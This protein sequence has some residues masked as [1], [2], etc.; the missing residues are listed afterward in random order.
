MVLRAEA[1]SIS[2]Q[3]DVS[4]GWLV[5]RFIC[6]DAKL[7]RHAGF[8]GSAHLPSEEQHLHAAA[9]KRATENVLSETAMPQHG[10]PFS[11]KC[12][13]RTAYTK[14]LPKM[15]GK[16][17]LLTAD[18]ASDEQLTLQ[19]LFQGKLTGLL[20]TCKDV[21]HAMRRVA[22]RTSFADPFLQKVCLV[23]I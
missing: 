16:I 4:K 1:D 11:N 10:M 14:L 19:L 23:V 9:S 13:R 3:Q 22:S 5:I 17:E 20:L 21:A 7:V 6:A 18:G 2:L 15:L 12:K 8:F